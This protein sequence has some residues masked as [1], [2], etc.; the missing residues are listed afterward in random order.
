MRQLLYLPKWLEVLMKI[1]NAPENK[2]YSQKLQRV[3]KMSINHLRA[4]LKRLENENFIQIY[5]S[6]KI[7]WI[8][9]TDK[10]KEVSQAVMS[11]KSSIK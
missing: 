5:P 6:K 9:L 8:I 2:R 1:N 4:I 7:K 11:I 3:L 10:G